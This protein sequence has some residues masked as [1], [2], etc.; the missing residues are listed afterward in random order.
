MNDNELNDH[1]ESLSKSVDW[2]CAEIGRL[3]AEN[4]R[5]LAEMAELK[6][7]NENLLYWIRVKTEAMSN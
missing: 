1:I 4:T 2:A 6:L 5:L 7:R 3:R